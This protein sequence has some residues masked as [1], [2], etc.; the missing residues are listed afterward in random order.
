[1]TDDTI[2]ENLGREGD[3]PASMKKVFIDAGH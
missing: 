2:K 1:M 3:W